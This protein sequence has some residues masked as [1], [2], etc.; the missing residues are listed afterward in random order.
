MEVSISTS[1]I[2]AFGFKLAKDAYRKDRDNRYSL[3]QD[4]TLPDLKLDLHS[5][6]GPLIRVS[7]IGEGRVRITVKEYSGDTCD[8]ATH[9]PDGLRGVMEGVLFH[10]PWYTEVPAM[11]RHWGMPEEEVRQIGDTIFSTI[12]LRAKAKNIVARLYFNAVWY[13]GGI[14]RSIKHRLPI[15]IIALALATLTSCSGCLSPPDHSDPASP[16][17][18]PVYE[19]TA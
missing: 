12:M 9:A 19:K 4:W 3:L 14:W 16:Y 10:D 2:A 18:P 8:G 7:P 1:Q 13:L 6:D 15:V 5:Y 17:T 11:A